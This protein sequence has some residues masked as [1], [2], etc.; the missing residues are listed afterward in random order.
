[1]KK[2]LIAAILA[3]ALLLTALPL[4][5]SA[6]GDPAEK[7]PLRG[8][9]V[10]RYLPEA[11]TWMEQ[12]LKQED[13]AWGYQI[14]YWMLWPGAQVVNFVWPPLRPIIERIAVPIIDLLNPPLPEFMPEPELP[15]AAVT[16]HSI[17]GYKIFYQGEGTPDETAAKILADTLNEITGGTNFAAETGMPSGAN[18]FLVGSISGADVSAL[19][20][21]GYLIGAD[22]S[23][24][25]IAGGARGVIYGVYRFLEK[26]FD[27][28]WYTHTLRVIPAGP[29]EIAE[30]KA[31]SYAPILEYRDTDWISP[32]DPV[33][34]L[35]NG[36]NGSVY[37]SLP[38]S[39]GGTFGYNGGM[40]HTFINYFVKPV[41]FFEDHPD[42]YAWRDD[43]NAR[44]PRQLC[45]TSDEVLAEMTR[46]V[47]DQ[48]RGGNGQPIVSVTQDD[49]QDYCQCAKCKAVDAEEGSHAG[50]MIRFANAIADAVKDEFPD[51]LI[52]TFAYQYTRTPPKITK[53]RD[54]VIVR[55]CSIECCFA[56]PLDDPSCAENVKFAGDIKTWSQISNHLYIWDYT[57]N[58][59]HYNCV[60]PDF[61][62]LQE[63]MQF[64][65]ANNVRG[66]YEEGNYQAAECDSEF[67]ELRAYLLARLMFDPYL[68]YS[69]EM[70]GFLKA[71]YGGGWQYM[72]EF[73][74]L[75][76]ANAGTK[77]PHSKLGIGNSP[78][79]KDLLN[80]KPNQIRYADQLWDKAIELAGSETCRQNVLRSQLSWRFWKG[81]NTSV[82]FWRLQ[83]EEKWQAANEQLYNDFKAFG[84][85]R[86]SEGG[87]WRFLPEPP[88]NWWN[89]PMDWRTK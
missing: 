72:R 7:P 67:A 78:T 12:G 28:H 86:Y 19:G 23:A 66:V 65:V 9:D 43:K 62:V 74:D 34:S 54:N 63:N 35:A 30:V 81:C 42:W 69:A 59:S 85:T 4:G 88:E 70:N 26:Y 51:A 41:D 3:A 14:L 36:L 48:L 80:L 44:V 16:K 60:F 49:N 46:E 50:T 71:Y 79:D 84:I 8:I 83:A 37:R 21:D 40:C 75:S 22:G 73:I 68:D 76:I 15:P 18:E 61:G 77:R 52:D 53:P 24:I 47:L 45:L 33:Y 56:H 13:W 82:E 57:T 55:L 31:E 39:Q 89:T 87:N 38:E 29:A 6:A 27:C 11:A 25:T 32:R 17:A 5:A 2:R 20:V 1:M 10:F 64:F 58:Y